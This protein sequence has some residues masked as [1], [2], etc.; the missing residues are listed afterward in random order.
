M[1][2]AQT[3]ME[4]T[5]VHATMD[6]VVMAQTALTSTNVIHHHLPAMQMPTA[7]TPMEVTH[8]HAVM[9]TLGM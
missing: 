1:L 7:Q 4:V 2:T 6:T 9:D 5:H 8:V 3:P